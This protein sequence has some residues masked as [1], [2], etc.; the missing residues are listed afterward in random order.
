MKKKQ[1]DRTVTIFFES[2]LE[3][4]M[5]MHKQLKEKLAQSKHGL[6]FVNFKTIAKNQIDIDDFAMTVGVCND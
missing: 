1:L 2:D 4:L 5:Q 6:V 3:T